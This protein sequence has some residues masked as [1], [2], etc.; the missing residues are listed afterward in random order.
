MKLHGAALAFIL[1]ATPAG[2]GFFD[3]NK[4]HELC[5][6]YPDF[7]ETYTMAVIDAA[8]IYQPL[9]GVKDRICLPKGVRSDQIRDVACKYLVDNP[10]IRHW[11]AADVVLES[12][13]AAWPCKRS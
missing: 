10:A 5:G 13:A 1:L 3:G 2:A 11:P 7:A 12:A 8:S 4:L 6:D 9:M